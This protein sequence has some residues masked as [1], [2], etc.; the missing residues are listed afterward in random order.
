MK[1]AIVGA[2]AMGQLFGARLQL[3]GEDVTLF[4]TRQETID[5]LNGSG[6]F[7]E[8]EE[9]TEHTP[10][11]V[12]RA[13]DRNGP[14]DLFVFFTKGFHTRAAVESIRHLVGP[15]S[16]GLT[17]QNG[18]GHAE[19]LSE[20]F[21]PEGTLAGVTDFPSDLAEVGHVKSSRHGSVRI[22]STGSNGHA[23]NVAQIL[24]RARLNVK[25]DHD[26]R[27]PIWEKVT[28]NSA[29]NTLSAVTGKVIGD[30]GESPDAR[31]IVSDVLSE[32][33]R[34][35]ASQGIDFSIERVSA[36]IE[37]AFANHP[38]HKTSMLVDL[39]AGRVTEVDFIGGAVAE[40]GS[41]SGVPTP[42]LQ[43]LCRLVRLRTAE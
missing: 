1:T 2:G 3:A 12:H 38:M 34:V 32:T 19:V 8:T 21:G 37:N 29:V 16:I 13:E 40:I 15:A 33:Q 6:V 17:L 7:V 22:G 5:T 26:V 14:F 42:V 27:V 30:L 28:F 4:D 39:E 23:E 25:V 36:A 31:E 24:D 10:V 11:T 35:A 41:K 20:L 9:G 43:T 18:L